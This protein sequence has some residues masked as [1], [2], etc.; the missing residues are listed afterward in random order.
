MG[1]SRRGVH[2]LAFIFLLSLASPLFIVNVTATA[3]M[4]DLDQ[5]SISIE[6]YSSFEGE[7]LAFNLTFDEISGNDANL[8][9]NVTIES[10][11][12]LFLGNLSSATHHFAPFEQ[13]MIQLN[14]TGIPFGYS[15]LNVS[16]EGDVSTTSIQSFE[17]IVQ[18]LRPMNLSLAGIGSFHVE[19][20]D[21]EHVL[22][23][24][25]SL[26]DG[27]YF[28]FQFPLINQGDFNWSGDVFVEFENG[29]GIYGVNLTGLEVERMSSYTVNITPSFRLIEGMLNWNVLVVG[30]MV[31]DQN[32][33]YRNGSFPI[34]P[35]P[36]PILH[37]LFQI[38]ARW[39]W[40]NPKNL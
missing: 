31:A 2:S 30:N 37:V 24:N 9:F 34:L 10:L 33:H 23:G 38:Q 20:L 18:R 36:L 8:S 32:A 6:N 4:L 5:N 1:G 39:N 29:N 16:I 11:E 13:R 25:L 3:G 35:P 14:V 28:S 26:H 17:R 21:A 19:G 27:D 22:S 12:G 7:I 15:V 40:V